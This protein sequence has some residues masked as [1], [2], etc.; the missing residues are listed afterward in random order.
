MP[1]TGYLWN[2][3]VKFWSPETGDV[4]VNFSV[5]A[6][7][8]THIAVSYDA[9]ADTMTFYKDGTQVGSSVSVASVGDTNT[10]PLFI[11]RDSQGRYVDGQMDEV[12]IWSDART[13][14]EISANYQKQLAGNENNLQAYY[15]FD[16]DPDGTTVANKA[17]ATGSALNGTLTG[18]AVIN[19]IPAHAADFSGGSNYIEVE[20][21]TGGI[22]SGTGS[23][24]YETWIQTT[25]TT[26]NTIMGTGGDGGGGA[27]M[28][29]NNGIIQ[30]NNTG[31][32]AGTG[33]VFGT[34]NVADGLWHHVAVVYDSTTGLATVYVDGVAEAVERCADNRRS[35]THLAISSS[36]IP[37]TIPATIMVA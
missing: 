14:D 33:E 3:E 4:D 21:P 26:L 9:N 8:W 20:N 27:T 32:A 11:G 2:G 24:T 7:T 25:E 13:A 15:R 19:N 16:D 30:F 5:S 10:D 34:S 28:R 18:D 17:T 1:T 36:A 23:F 37:I 29:I 6:D 31:E 22:I 12:R 35:A